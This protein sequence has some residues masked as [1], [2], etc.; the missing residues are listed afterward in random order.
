MRF[1]DL[2]IEMTV[3]QLFQSHK[4]MSRLGGP[5]KEMGVYRT[6]LRSYPANYSGGYAAP[7]Q[8]PQLRVRSL[9]LPV[10]SED[11]V[12]LITGIALP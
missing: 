11:P 6:D 5:L 12:W 2:S 4:W 9:R 10:S 3:Q 8:L 1:I 7:L